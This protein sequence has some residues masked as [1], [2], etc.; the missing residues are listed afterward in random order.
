MKEISQS[1]HSLID[2]GLEIKKT[3]SSESRGEIPV[4]K[5]KY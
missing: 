3:S 2:S 1:F 5:Q 4:T